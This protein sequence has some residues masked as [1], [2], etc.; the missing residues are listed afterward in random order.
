MCARDS[1]NSSQSQDGSCGVIEFYDE[2][3]DGIVS[4]CHK[5]DHNVFNE[6]NVIAND[7]L[8]IDGEHEDDDSDDDFMSD[9][10]PE[11]VGI[12]QSCTLP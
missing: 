2:N 1:Y 6:S 9:K 4:D 7:E 10:L 11:N 12:H 5:E 3:N 8:V